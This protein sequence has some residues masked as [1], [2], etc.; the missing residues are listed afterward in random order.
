[1]SDSNHVEPENPSAEK[2]AD[3]LYIAT[4]V[5][6]LTYIAVIFAYVIL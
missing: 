1:M 6:V 2:L 3:R 4:T 5:S